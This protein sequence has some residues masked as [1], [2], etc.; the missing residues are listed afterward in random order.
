MVRA[1]VAGLA[2]AFVAFTAGAH[3]LKGNRITGSCSSAIC[4]ALHVVT[5]RTPIS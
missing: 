2:A 3:D 5:G 1:I 4:A